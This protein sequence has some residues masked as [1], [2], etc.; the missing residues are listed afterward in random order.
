[1][2]GQS[3]RRGTPHRRP[4]RVECAHCGALVAVP[5]LRAH[6]RSGRCARER[7]ALELDARL[8]GAGQGVGHAA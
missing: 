7:A 3:L 5:N 6:E 2:S 1:M 4:P 8:S